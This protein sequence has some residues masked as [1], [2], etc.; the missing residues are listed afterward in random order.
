MLRKVANGR[1]SRYIQIGTEVLAV[2]FA[3]AWFAIIGFVLLQGA[4]EVA[5]ML[6]VFTLL[7][8]GLAYA[9]ERPE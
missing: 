7:I 8:A 4:Y 3:I 2:L 5:G 1:T 6:L 9:N